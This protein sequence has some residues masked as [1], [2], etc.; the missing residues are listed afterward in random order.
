MIIVGAARSLHS[1]CHSLRVIHSIRSASGR[2]EAEEKGVQE[3]IDKF[4]ERKKDR[5]DSDNGDDSDFGI[6]EDNAEDGTAGKGA[7]PEDSSR[8]VEGSFC[9]R[10][11]NCEAC[12]EQEDKDCDRVDN[13]GYSDSIC[14]DMGDGFSRVENF[15]FCE[16]GSGLC[17]GLHRPGDYC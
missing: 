7:T 17:C 8:R 2:M 3:V 13:H 6:C 12:I 4:W 14:M 11:S 10:A 9:L 1:S 5:S 15:D 16:Y